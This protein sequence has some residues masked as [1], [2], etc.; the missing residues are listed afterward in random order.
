MF[1]LATPKYLSTFKTSL[2][3]LEF[4]MILFSGVDK[5]L[6]PGTACNMTGTLYGDVMAQLYSD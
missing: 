2:H 5:W 1:S 4:P 6:F 3:P